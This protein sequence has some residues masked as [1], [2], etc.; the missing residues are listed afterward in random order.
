MLPDQP[1]V[2]QQ[3]GLGGPSSG[4]LILAPGSGKGIRSGGH[5]W[6][7]SA[8]SRGR[9]NRTCATAGMNQR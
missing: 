8:T 3:G 6:R 2:G 4:C 9:R 5:G 7:A 1:Q